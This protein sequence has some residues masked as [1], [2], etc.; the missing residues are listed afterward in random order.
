MYCHNAEDTTSL[1]SWRVLPMKCAATNAYLLNVSAYMYL[2]NS[3]REANK[4]VSF[5][6]FQVVA[7]CLQ[8]NWLAIANRDGELTIR[9]EIRKRMASYHFHEPIDWIDCHVIE[10]YLY[11]ACH[12][13]G[14]N[15]SICFLKYRVSDAPL[16]EPGKYVVRV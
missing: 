9:F 15:P 13:N 10:D 5:L 1:L 8:D 14:D 6:P 2:T 16:Y 7:A 12:V 11:I 3:L 4:G